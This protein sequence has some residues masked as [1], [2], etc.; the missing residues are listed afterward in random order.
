MIDA[1]GRSP[2]IPAT[3]ASLGADSAPVDFSVAGNMLA[4]PQVLDD[5]AAAFEAGSAL[6]LA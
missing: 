6:P 5:T 1:R 2:P 3:R 4:G